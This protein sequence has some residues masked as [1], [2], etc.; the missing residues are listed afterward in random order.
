[1]S[2]VPALRLA[3]S[4]HWMLTGNAALAASQWATIALLARF[5][6]PEILGAYALGLSVASVAFSLTNLELRTLQVTD[7]AEQESFASYARL[8]IATSVATAGGLGLAGLF[9]TSPLTAL[10]MLAVGL[11]K[12]LDGLSDIIYGRLQRREVT[13]PIGKSQLSKAV[14]SVLLLGGTL[15]LAGNTPWA[16]GVVVAPYALV[17]F[18]FELPA[19]KRHG[20]VVL[21][22]LTRFWAISAGRLW[23]LARSGFPLT[24]VNTLVTLHAAVPRLA[25]AG[26]VGEAG[27]GIL[28]ALGYLAVAPNLLLVAMGQA[29]MRSL[30][31]SFATGDRR[32]YLKG[33]LRMLGSAA[34]VGIATLLAGA[35]WGG[36]LLAALY[37]TRF[38]G[39]D[40]ELALFL[41]AGAVSYLN[42]AVGYSLSSARVFREQIPMMTMVCA[43]SLAASWPLVARWGIAGAALAQ[44]ISM[45]VQLAWS[46]LLLVRTV[47]TRFALVP[48][49]RE[50]VTGAACSP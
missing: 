10:A 5:S 35:W 38:L 46:A 3:R 20:E 29:S 40:R 42:T 24:V 18:L 2:A 16:L 36:S 13:A 21:P 50:A 44:L 45:L 43:A 1:M 33:I 15:L 27:V 26:E 22:E 25:V 47:S 31:A 19:L 4:L 23:S 14:L 41:S 48:L 11:Q 17:L 32:G 28:A 12:F 37:G 34:A 39:Y 49:E 8:R 9:V 6:T 30:A 7:S